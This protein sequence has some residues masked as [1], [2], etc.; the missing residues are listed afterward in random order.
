MSLVGVGNSMAGTLLSEAAINI[1]T[2]QDNKPATKADIKALENSLKRFQ[3]IQNM[4]AD[5]EGRLPYYDMRRMELVYL[6]AN[7]FGNNRNE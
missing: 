2:K 1:F 3:R 4:A 6:K 5:S 7:P